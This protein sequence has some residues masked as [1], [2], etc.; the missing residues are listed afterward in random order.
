[1]ISYKSSY[2]Y[3]LVESY[4]METGILPDDTVVTEYL[5]LARGGKLWINAGYCWDG[6]SGPTFDSKSSM[7]GG[8]VH[9]ALY[10]LIRLGHLDKKNRKK[11]D[12][13]AAK[14]WKEDGMWVWRANSWLKALEWFGEGSTLPSA[15]KPVQ[16]A[17]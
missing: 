4:S 17:P 3:Q 2:K 6:C 11:A 14:I 10:Q 9:D 12:A 16:V 5:V 15:E 13:L 1:M 8:L 7:R